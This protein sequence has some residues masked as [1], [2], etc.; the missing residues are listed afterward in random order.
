M[1]SQR[2]IK[3]TAG[4]FL[5]WTATQP[6]GRFELENGV[7]IEMAAEQAQ[8]ALM[9][10]AATKA[11]ERGLREAH[12]PC[13]VFP[14]GMTAVVD[15]EHVRLPDA[16]VQCSPVDPEA[17]RLSSPII[18]VE[19]VSPTSVSRD[20]DL[21]LVDYFLIP[22]VE[23]YLIL[24]PRRRKVVHFRRSHDGRSDVV[25]RFLTSGVIDLTPPGFCVAVEDLL[26]P[27]AGSV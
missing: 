4:R 15:E 22:S 12:L 6:N 23:H 8:H 2:K 9:K 3:M 27:V 20:E 16:S 7:I 10:F 14:D 11:L 24:Y 18:L 19:V 17:T 26:G 5:D 25:T 1:T 13:T 21:K